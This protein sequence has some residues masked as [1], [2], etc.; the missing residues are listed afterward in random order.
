MQIQICCPTHSKVG[1]TQAGFLRP[2]RLLKVTQSSLTLAK[3]LRSRRRET[4][5]RRSWR[6]LNWVTWSGS[7]CLVVWVKIGF[8]ILQITV[9]MTPA[10]SFL[11]MTWLIQAR[12]LGITNLKAEGLIGLSDDTG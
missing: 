10:H 7:E 8:I 12:C 5:G 9:Y 4:A 1:I 11:V 6:I 2:F 3:D